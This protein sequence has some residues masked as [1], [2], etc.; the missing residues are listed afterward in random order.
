MTD[1]GMRPEGR[2][3][4]LNF[5]VGVP[6]DYIAREPRYADLFVAQKINPELAMSAASLDRP[7][8]GWHEELAARF[9]Q[10][11]LVPSVHLPFNDLHPGSPDKLILKASRARLTKAFA[12]A[13]I[14]S[15]GF[16]VGHLDYNKELHADD[17]PGWRERA[18][19]TWTAFLDA[20]PD[21]PPLY[22]ENTYEFDPEPLADVVSGLAG[23]GVG[24][25]FDVG[26]WHCFAQGWK[27]RDLERWVKGLAPHIR[28][29]HLHDNDGSW[30]Q[31]LGLGKGK[32]D[33]PAFFSL[34]D[35]YGIKSRA[36]FEPHSEEAWTATQSFMARR[37]ELFGFLSIEN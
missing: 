6:L 27:R 37:P 36:T 15:P 16:M 13:R 2:A 9:R 33:W 20:W 21:S 29:L 8:R 32:I 26:H 10:A 31:H 18:M 17:Y 12:L 14:Y 28:V 4:R 11:G 7:D 24:V 23:R 1:R 30:D 34:L 25:C 3:G 19:D 5:N 35:R 22:L